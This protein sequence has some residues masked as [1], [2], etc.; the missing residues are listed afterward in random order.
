MSLQ[1]GIRWVWPC[2]DVFGQRFHAEG[3]ETRALMRDKEVL[4]HLESALDRFA[5]VAERL[6]SM[7]V[8]HG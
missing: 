2:E 3:I 7:A 4:A 6:K 1:T 5:A 8:K